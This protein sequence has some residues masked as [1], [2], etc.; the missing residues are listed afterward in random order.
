MDLEFSKTNNTE[1]QAKLA[2]K[3]LLKSLLDII[4]LT[5]GSAVLYVYLYKVFESKIIKGESGDHPFGVLFN[6][7]VVNFSAGAWIIIT[8]ASYALMLMNKIK[9]D[10]NHIVFLN[11]ISKY[12]LLIA[13]SMG[14]VYYINFWFQEGSS[15]EMFKAHWH[16]VSLYIFSVVIAVYINGIN[17]CKSQNVINIYRYY[18]CKTNFILFSHVAIIFIPCCLLI[19]LGIIVHTCLK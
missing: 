9:Y 2:S 16:I 14:T 3:I 1:E 8:L 15:I 17:Y 4:E 11:R 18:L 7:N 6:L 19:S 10:D 12:F 13:C 5:V